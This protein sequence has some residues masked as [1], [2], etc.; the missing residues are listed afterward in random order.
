M[1]AR[2]YSA[3]VLR[4]APGVFRG[5]VL[6]RDGSH[7]VECAPRRTR[8]QALRDAQKQAARLSSPLAP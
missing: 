2:R 7:A 8:R 3:S 6:R 5:L 1:S 4:E